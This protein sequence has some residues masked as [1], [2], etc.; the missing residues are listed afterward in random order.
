MRYD[1]LLALTTRDG[2]YEHCTGDRPLPEHG[3]CV[4]DVARALIVVA[5]DREA[6][7]PVVAAGEVYLR[8]LE[9]A[10]RDDGTV[11]NRRSVAGEWRGPASTDDHWGRALWAWGT[12][13]H[14]ALRSDWMTRSAACFRRSVGLRSEYTR[15][16]AHAA[17]GAAEF[18]ERF[19]G[20]VAALALLADSR[21]ALL[22]GALDRWPWPEERLTYANAI[23]PQALILAGH[24]LRDR[25]TRDRGLGMLDWLVELQTCHD[26][27]SLIGCQGWAPGEPL[28]AFDQQPIEV[29]HLV[30]A[31]VTAFE[32][33]GDKRW[34]DRVLMGE[35]W[36]CGDNDANVGMHD[37]QTGAGFDGLRRSGRNDNRGAESTCAFLST[38]G[39]AQ[40]LAARQRKAS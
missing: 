11:V 37:P 6:P 20:D 8:F 10:Q 27:L 17:L 18:L 1:H 29:A 28:P 13:T 34:R 26:H 38:S 36:F 23:V 5:R 31:C 3:Y 16:M 14:S 32:V 2:L 19:P 22:R 40:R 12:V 25:Q 9:E 35:Q 33:T 24:H 21:E 7:A 30:D 39:Q 15:S 4:D